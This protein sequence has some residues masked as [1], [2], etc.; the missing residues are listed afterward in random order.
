MKTALRVVG[1]F[2]VM[3]ACFAALNLIPFVLLK[4]AELS[5][6]RGGIPRIL[7]MPYM[8][9]F[10]P[11]ASGYLAVSITS[12]NLKCAKATS[13]FSAFVSSLATVDILIT[14]LFVFTAAT[15]KASWSQ[16]TVLIAQTAA[17][18]LGVWFGC[19]VLRPA[20]DAA[21]VASDIAR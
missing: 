7:M 15:G 16:T 13:F 12:S 11:A 1:A 2:A 21:A 20:E 14:L 19:G 6:H 5:G 8:W 10:V 18:F 17:Q 9:V 3:F 4:M